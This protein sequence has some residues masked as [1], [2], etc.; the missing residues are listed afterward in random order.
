[1]TGSSYGS[2]VSA[3]RLR[4]RCLNRPRPSLGR[5]LPELSVEIVRR[6][7]GLRTFEV[8][9]RQWV[10][11]RTLAWISSYRRCARDYER[12]PASHEATVYWGHDH[13]H[14]PARVA[15]ARSGQVWSGRLG[16]GC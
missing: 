3:A 7:E 4:S 6:P 15:W 11:E 14:D 9:P 8:L 10:I 13:R 1:M 5:D 16:P 12:L 2:M